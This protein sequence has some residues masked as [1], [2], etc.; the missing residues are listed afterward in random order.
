MLNILS[1]LVRG[2]AAA[3]PAQRRALE[4]ALEYMDLRPGQPIL[5]QKVDVVFVG[6]CTNGRISD[7]RLAASVLQGRKVASGVRVMVVPG[8]QEVKKQAEN[9]GLAEIFTAAGA[10]RWRT[11]DTAKDPTGRCWPP[12]PTRAFTAPFPFLLVQH[13]TM[14]ALAFEYFTIWRIIYMDGRPHPADI[15][16]YPDF[17]GHSIGR[18]EG[19]ALVVDTVGIDERSW[20]DTAGHEHSDKLHVVER[21]T[22]PNKNVLH[23]EALIDDPGAYTKPFRV[24]WDIPWRANAELSEYICQE[25]EQD[26]KHIQGPA[27]TP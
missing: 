22:R 8:S 21:F 20:L 5:G 15:A 9:E 24:A 1:T 18:W 6:S 7:L 11:V 14:I 26:S 17:M 27:G 4:R 12:G 2:A 23:Y 19:S 13:P 10:E 16:D 25:N 3:D